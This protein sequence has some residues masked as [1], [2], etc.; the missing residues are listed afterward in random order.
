MMR[1]YIRH[2]AL[3][4]HVPYLFIVIN[5]SVS[6]VNF[7]EKHFLI[8][9]TIFLI[10]KHIFGCQKNHSFSKLFKIIIIFGIFK[11]K[12]LFLKFFFLIFGRDCAE[13]EGVCGGGG[14]RGSFFIY[15]F[16]FIYLFFFFFDF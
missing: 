14:V 3:I 4:F 10:L 1:S 5:C 12:N 8:S 13:L 9:K 11:K 15:L 7:R 2:S 16:I 6:K